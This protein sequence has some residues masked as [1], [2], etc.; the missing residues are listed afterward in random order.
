M[1]G[2]AENSSCGKSPRTIPLT[3][4]KPSAILLA[5]NM[6][7]SGPSACELPKLLAAIR[8][9]F[10]KSGSRVDSKHLGRVVFEPALTPFLRDYSKSLVREHAMTL[11]SKE[12]TEALGATEPTLHTLRATPKTCHWGY[13][14]ASPAHQKWR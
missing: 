2:K 7:R 8:V 14:D 10:L 9:V 4:R 3:G 5:L 12:R 1:T 6:A 13:F 11:K